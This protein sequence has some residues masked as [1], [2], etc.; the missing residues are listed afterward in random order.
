[1][2]FNKARF[3]MV[4]Q[5][6]RPWDVLDFDLLDTLESIPRELFVSKE[7][8]G[9]AYADLPLKLDNGSMMLEPKIVARMVQGLTLSKTDRVMEIGTGSGY[10]TA[11]L[12]TLVDSV[13]TYDVDEQQL[14]RAQAVLQSLNFDNIQFVAED[15]FANSQPE[16]KYDAIYV[17]G[18]LPEVP[19]QLKQQLADGG[20][21]VVVVGGEPVQRC[22]QITRNGNEFS[23]KTLFDTLVTPLTAKAKKPN[24]FQF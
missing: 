7:Q 21:L 20:R 5:Q 12:A 10:A 23:Q 6:I 11:V 9:Y 17:G 14:S 15:G 4:E 1:M 8:Q 16:A 19:E 3:N 24:K 18:S 13:Q 22:L 2:D